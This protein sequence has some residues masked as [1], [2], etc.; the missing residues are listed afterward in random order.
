ML[1]LRVANT[2]PLDKRH[3]KL[4]LFG[5]TF[6]PVKMRPATGVFRCKS[7]LSQAGELILHKE[8]RQYVKASFA[9]CNTRATMEQTRNG[10]ANDP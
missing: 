1:T 6:Q 5:V 7:E 8:T 2:L 10:R 9:A 4:D 3:Q